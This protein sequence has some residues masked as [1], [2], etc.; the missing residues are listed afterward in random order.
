MKQLRNFLIDK[1]LEPN[2]GVIESFEVIVE[3]DQG[4]WKW[5]KN[6]SACFSGENYSILEKLGTGSQNEFINIIG[7][8][9][10]GIQIIFS[11]MKFV[12]RKKL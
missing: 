5:I 6:D 10:Q 12:I 1:C 4:N 7:V 3:D 8:N 11:G 9:N 2:Y